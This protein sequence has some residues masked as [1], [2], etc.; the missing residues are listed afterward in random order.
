[1]KESGREALGSLG[2]D[3][4]IED[5]GREALKSVENDDSI[6]DQRNPKHQHAQEHR[7]SVLGL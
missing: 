4:S 1:M 5:S 2:N 6:E 3:D 7:V